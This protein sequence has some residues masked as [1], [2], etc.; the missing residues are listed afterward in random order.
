MLEIRKLSDNDIVSAITLMKEFIF[1]PPPVGYE[2]N[3]ANWVANFLGLYYKS[4]ED[5]NAV[6]LGC[7]DTDDNELMGFISG[8]T[9]ISS[10]DGLPTADMK[11]TVTFP[12][13]QQAATFSLLFDA[14][15]KHYYDNGIVTWRFDSIRKEED[16]H[17]VTNFIK[18]YYGDT[19]DIDV[20]VSIRGHQLEK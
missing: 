20:F 9:F 10:Y 7:F 1:D 6:V 12:E 2:M 8:D 17:K 11:D 3:E 18:K 15:L 14:F 19:N 4:K 16:Q 13:K 5:P